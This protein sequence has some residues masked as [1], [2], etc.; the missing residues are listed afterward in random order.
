[1]LIGLIGP[2]PVMILGKHRCYSRDSTESQSQRENNKS[3]TIC[4]MTLR[5]G[6]LLTSNDFEQI[7]TVGVI[8][9]TQLIV[10]IWIKNLYIYNFLFIWIHRWERCCQSRLNTK[11][12][13][14]P[15]VSKY[16]YQLFSSM[17]TCWVSVWC[18]DHTK[19]PG[20][21]FLLHKF[22]T[23]S[24]FSNIQT[25]GLI[26]TECICKRKIQPITIIGQALSL[27][28]MNMSRL[29]ERRRQS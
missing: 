8:L 2:A 23:P 16:P 20:P 13:C 14:M 21:T 17:W 25:T 19:W 24:L 22:P 6:M 15:S 26:A 3:N 29:E 5:G 18:I 7:R 28:M 11:T 4:L 10:K 12:R 1:M 27:L 9:Q